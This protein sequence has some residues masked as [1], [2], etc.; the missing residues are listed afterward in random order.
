MKAAEGSCEKVAE[1]V[2]ALGPDFSVMSGDDGLT[3]PF[4]STGATGVISVA[5]N[6]VVAPLVKMVQAANKNDYTTARKTYLRDHSI[7]RCT[8]S[9]E[10]S[11][12]PHTRGAGQCS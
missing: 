3:I 8:P 11:L 4:M 2:R 1:Y 5:S 6:L 10:Q 7:R 9:A 12:K